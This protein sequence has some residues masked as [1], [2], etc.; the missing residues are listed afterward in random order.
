[1]LLDSGHIQENDVEYLNK[2]RARKGE[3][4]VEPLYTQADADRACRNSPASASGSP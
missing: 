2:Q 1:M 3:P 4:P